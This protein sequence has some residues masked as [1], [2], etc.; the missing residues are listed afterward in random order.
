M[1]TYTLHF[2][3]SFLS[4]QLH[5]L[6]IIQ[7]FSSTKI[8]YPHQPKNRLKNET[9]SGVIKRNSFSSPRNRST[10]SEYALAA[11][12]ESPNVITG[13]PRFVEVRIDFDSGIT[14]TTDNPN[15]SSI[16][17]RDKD[18]SASARTGSYL[19]IRRVCVT[20]IAPSSARRERDDMNP[21]ILS[22]SRQLVGM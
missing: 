18:S 15:S 11:R 21:I 7:I 22:A 5:L 9:G 4:W 3:I 8:P 1:D 17:T 14:P 20:G 19:V 2:L 6:K 13:L 12:S 16:S 10:I